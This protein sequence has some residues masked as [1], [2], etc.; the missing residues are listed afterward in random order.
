MS[1]ASGARIGRGPQVAWIQLALDEILT[2]TGNLHGVPIHA[3]HQLILAP[4]LIK[5]KVPRTLPKIKVLMHLYGS[6]EMDLGSSCTSTGTVMGS[7]FCLLTVITKRS[8]HQSLESG[9]KLQVWSAR[10]SGTVLPQGQHSPLDLVALLVRIN[11]QVLS[12]DYDTAVLIFMYLHSICD[13]RRSTRS[14]LPHRESTILIYHR[15]T[16]YR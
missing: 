13:H 4:R 3:E 10:R 6:C 12:N 9:L 8:M 14:C 11:I 2:A 5:E 7:T 16:R 15:T 1:T